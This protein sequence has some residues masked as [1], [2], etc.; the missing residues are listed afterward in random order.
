MTAIKF[1]KN[2][3]DISAIVELPL[4]G[5]RQINQTIPYNDFSQSNQTLITSMWRPIIQND[6]LIALEV[7]IVDK[8]EETFRLPSKPFRDKHLWQKLPEDA[9]FILTTESIS[10][11]IK[12]KIYE[13]SKSYHMERDDP[14]KT[15]LRFMIKKDKIN[16]FTSWLEKH[17]GKQWLGAHTR[18]EGLPLSNMYVWGIQQ[19][20]YALG[21]VKLQELD[22]KIYCELIKPINLNKVNF[23][24][25]VAPYF[26]RE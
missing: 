12:Y 25:V 17:P 2:G 19:I 13:S 8:Q 16:I 11:H 4:I 1:T 23:P 5:K 6:V 10:Q 15:P 21:V 18:L 24:Q 9:K 22:G 3:V 7:N 14:N 20:L 26:Q